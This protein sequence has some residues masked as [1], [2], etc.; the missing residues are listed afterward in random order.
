MLG[1]KEKVSAAMWLPLL[2][3]LRCGSRSLLYWFDPQAAMAADSA[4]YMT[5]NPFDRNFFL[6]LEFLGLGVLIW[7]RFDVV[8]F[9]RH[10]PFLVLIYTYLLVSLLW[11]DFPDVSIRRWGRTLGDILMALV[12]VSESNVP[13]AVS[14]MYRRFAYVLIPMSVLF[15]KYF[16][17]LGVAYDFTGQVEMWVGV[18]THKNSL[19]QLV[20]LSLLLLLWGFL[21]RKWTA[22]DIPVF[23]MALWLLAGSR[24]SN[25]KTSMLV[26]LLGAMLLF[27]LSRMR[28][29]KLIGLGVSIGV[30]LVFVTEVVLEVFFQSSIFNV[31][32]SSTGRDATL[33][34]RT[35]LWAALIEMGMKHPLLGAGYGSFWLG[36]FTNT[37][38]KQFVWHPLQA[39]N[40]YIDIFIDVGVVGLLLV[41]FQVFWG[42]RSSYREIKA[43]GDLGKL[44][45]MLILM[46]VVYNISESSFIK[47][48]SLLWFAFL[49]MSIHDPEGRE[50]VEEL[51]KFYGEGQE[52]VTVSEEEG[53]S[54]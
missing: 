47:P 38:W 28:N 54:V 26:F 11:S 6:A 2:W 32:V 24:T 3:V 50:R 19:G 30:P 34:G 41:A 39:H 45:L 21:R 17:E 40:G 31:V 43:G 46:I 13:A 27:A 25:S 51:P 22:L 29:A 16:R 52:P 42:L 44:R 10:N 12:V 36:D 20:T 37:L 9:I 33:T 23:L 7:R 18:T 5:G 35:D 8:Y 1:E 53:E 4:D 14:W 15:V 48:T 49:V